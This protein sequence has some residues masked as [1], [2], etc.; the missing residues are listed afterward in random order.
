M[1]R[2]PHLRLA[3]VEDS[4]HVLLGRFPQHRPGVVLLRESATLP[5]GARFE[6]SI[7]DRIVS[8]LKGRR[9]RK[10]YR[11]FG[12]MRYQPAKPRPARRI[13]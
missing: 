6:P 4:R 9:G 12:E 10:A 13:A 5:S 11:R 8:E 7:E 2:Y 1:A 3:L